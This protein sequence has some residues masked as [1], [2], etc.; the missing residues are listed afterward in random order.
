[1]SETI[2]K[3]YREFK[4]SSVAVDNAT[5]VFLLTFMI[6]LFGIQ[7]YQNMPKEQY[8]D[9]S[10]PTVFINTPYFGN[11]AEEVENLVTRPLEKEINSITG[12]KTLRS[13]SIQDFSV[14]IAEFDSDMEIDDAV[15]K[16]KDAVDKAK[17]ELP[18]DL[19]EDPSVEEINFAEI[20]IVTV[21]VSGQYNMDD[22]RKYAEYLED[23]IEEIKEVSDVQLKGALDREVKI[24][25]DL[26]K[27]QSLKLNFNDIET[28]IARENVTMS[29][30]EL[31]NNESRRALRVVGQF[32]KVEEISNLIVKAEFQKPIYLKDIAE[33][34]YAFEERVSYARS[35]GLP[36]I[37]LD[38]IKRSGEN[39]LSTAD[40]LKIVIAEAEK[41]LPEGLEVSLFN[42]LSVYTRNE[43]NNLENSII[44]GV[45]LVILVLL[46]F[47]GLRN[48]LFV[49]LAIPLSM[50][51]GI[52]IL[53]VFGVIMNIVVLF[54]LI[55]ALGLL[56]D[57]AI[58]VVENIYR[59]MQNDYEHH[60]AAKYGAGEVAWPIIAS[61]ATT[62]AAF[63]PLIFWP[64]MMGVF[65]KYMPI[66]L[67]IVLSS[68]LFVALVI[69]PVFTSRFMKIDIK[70]TDQ[71]LA[72]R[73]TRNVIT[74]FILMISLAGIAHVAG[75]DWMR[76]LLC[77]AALIS[78]LNHFVLRPAS[79]GFQ[80][81]LLPLLEK[82]Y[83]HF[84]RIALKGKNAFLTLI[85]TIILLFVAA[86]I[87]VA[88]QPKIDFFPEAD[89]L[90]I[91]I[92]VDLPIGSDIE[93]TNK[94]VRDLESKIKKVIEPN[95]HI[96]EAV[97][98]QIGEDT[99]D[100]NTP[101]EPGVTPNKARITVAFLEYKDR[102]GIS[103][104]SIME[105][106]RSEILGSP[107][108]KISVSPNAGGPPTGKA[109]NL[110]IIGPEIDSLLVISDK[111]IKHIN[112]Q[113]IPG[114]EELKADT[115]LAKPEVLVNIDR[116]SARRYNV[117]TGQI[118]SALRTSVFGKEVSKFKVGEDEYPIMVRL[119]EQYRNSIGDLINQKITFMD[120]NSGKILQVPVSSVA[121]IEYS[122]TYN[123]IRRKN[124][125]RVVTISSN[126]L[127]GYNANEI[128]SEIGKIMLDYDLPNTYSYDFTGE[129]QQQAEDTAFLS[130]AFMVALFA[131]FIIL[132]TQFNSI[133]SPF[134]II[135]SV[136]FSTIGVFLGYA[137]SGNDITIIFTGVGIISL[138]GIVV[139]NAIVLID[140]INLLIQRKR[141]SLGMDSPSGL[142]REVVKDLIIEGGA[143]RLRPVL[144][145]AI[146][147]VLGLIPL[148]IG[149]N[150]NF[151]SFVSELDPKFFLGGDNTALWGPM[152]WTIIYGIIFATFLTLV[153]VPAMYW[154]AYNAKMNL[155]KSLNKSG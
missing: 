135:L 117:S 63:L 101:P 55:L 97:L 87:F 108:V 15:R 62:L 112:A 139:N 69:N 12:I 89:P 152:A 136:V 71:N 149:F 82:F 113:N 142:S 4:L 83:N 60:A 5:S 100:P 85:G 123:A 3:L 107:G 39:L 134:I 78:I 34:K 115:E 2:K 103:T 65:M 26:I 75:V 16:T 124:T 50:L 74:G 29:G 88:S 72:K 76:N 24:N 73:K 23:K 22:L 32:S 111:L 154:L 86:F 44:S 145:T 9:A 128:N 104:K 79:F 91:N 6:L 84:I 51:T 43:V 119:N 19:D 46:F 36:V 120:Q 90:Y 96:V 150:F 125:D 146:T 61:T 116:G 1:M 68:S 10:L 131:I 49:G 21:N 45:I 54:S 118:A 53:H 140:Y 93:A 144:L 143:T 94:I 18:G 58:V 64:G 48:A 67:I 133:I 109:I 132:V 81:R 20:P 41:T 56:V 122:S 105:E 52:L 106:I 130:T 98:T 129:Q 59:Y 155:M 14:L 70:S 31:I 77:I 13:T 151:F 38:V 80:N 7:S 35:D 33:V 99:T 127:E 40:K 47:L 92:F 25:V 141:E 126:V 57:N 8:P 11:S 147:T 27:M 95:R 66:T 28:A 121:D 30:G 138:A 110:E 114:I 102:D 42:D 148:A 17:S 137:A 153:V 37:A